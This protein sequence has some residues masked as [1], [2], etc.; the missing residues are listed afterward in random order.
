MRN[1]VMLA[2]KKKKPFERAWWLVLSNYLGMTRT[3]LLNYSIK[4]DIRALDSQS[5]LTILW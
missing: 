4:A 2:V 1:L 3:V 5:D